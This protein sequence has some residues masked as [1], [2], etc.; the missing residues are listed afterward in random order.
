MKNIILTLAIATLFGCAAE[1][2]SSYLSSNIKY[3]ALDKEVGC[4]SKYS[5]DK[6]EDV[7]DS[8]YKNTWMTWRGEVVFAES[9]QVSLNVDGFGSQDLNVEFANESAGYD[10]S[11]GDHL[12]VKF[13]MKI[14]GGCIMPFIGYH[15]IIL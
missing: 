4:S 12:T 10:V 2:T 9:D 11:V 7:F 15:A 5:D 8:K 14:Q 3:T 1:D 6:K 13:V